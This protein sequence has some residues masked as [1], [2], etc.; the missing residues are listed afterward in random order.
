MMQSLTNRLLADIANSPIDDVAKI[1]YYPQNNQIALVALI[2][3]IVIALGII[4]AGS[5]LII[6]KLKK[7]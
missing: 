7:K 4:T 5:L 2:L 6:K 3:F 1:I